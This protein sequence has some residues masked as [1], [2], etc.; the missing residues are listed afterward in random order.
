MP[1]SRSTRP[2]RLKSGRAQQL[3]L[4]APALLLVLLL[5]FLADQAPPPPPA[6]LPLENQTPV[7][8]APLI[9]EPRVPAN[10]TFT[11]TAASATTALAPP[12]AVDALFAAI[13]RP[14][15]FSNYPRGPQA[16]R[17]FQTP[18][19]SVVSE[20]ALNAPPVPLARTPADGR[21]FL[22]PE[23]IDLHTKSARRMVLDPASLEQV[24]SGRAG[25]LLVPTPQG[26]VLNVELRQ[27]K[28]RGGSTHTLQGEVAGEP[29]KSSAQFVYHDGVL[30]GSVARFHL[31]QEIEY[32]IL[33]DGHLMVRELDQ[34]SMRDLCNDPGAP[35]VAGDTADAPEQAP[36]QGGTS[37]PAATGEETIAGDTPGYTTVD[38]VVGY[39]KSAREADGGHAQIEARIVA[40]VDRMNLAFSNSQVASTELMLL[41]T[42]EDP[43]Y[44]FPGKTAGD[45]GG[46]DELG[47]LENTAASNPNLNTVSDYAT[48]LGADLQAFVL[49][50]AD[51]SAGVAYRPGRSS[52]TARDYMTATRITFA[53]ELGHNFGARHSWGDTSGTDA[54][55]NVHS[56]GWRLA[57]EGHPRV[58]TIMAYDWAWGSGVR[59]PY[60]AN[61]AV[62]YQGARTGQ[63]DGYNA[64]G[65]AL[66]D[67]RYVSG[68]YVGSLGAGFN[69]S[70]P[71]LGARNAPYLLTQAAGRAALRTRSAFQ[72]VTPAT[73]VTWETGSSREIYWRGGDHS[74]TVDIE[75]YR[76]G[77][78]QS[79]LVSGRQGH[80]R[81]Y[82]WAIPA[83][84]PS[85][86]NYM[87][88]IRRNG[89][90]TADSGLF[91]I[92]G[93]F[94]GVNPLTGLESTGEQGG[95]FAPSEAVY[96]LTNT[97][98]STLQWTAEASVPWVSLGSTGGS[99]SAGGSTPLTVS[100]NASANTLPSGLHT[101]TLTVSAG[102]IHITR[103]L[104][105]LV[106]GA[107]RLAVERPEGVALP[108]EEALDFGPWPLRF[109][110]R[111][112]FTLRNAGGSNLTLGAP[113]IAS[114]GGQFEFVGLS[115]TT[116]GIMGTAS[117]D[118]AFQPGSPGL[119][120]AVL[121][122]SSNDP[123]APLVS[124]PLVGR[125]VTLPGG[126]EMVH[127][128][129]FTAAGIQPAN[130]LPLG[131]QVVFSASTTAH[132]AEL[133]RSDGTAAGTYLV[134][135][136]NPG[137]S[138]SSISNLTRLG[139]RAFFSATSTTHGNELWVTDG[140]L[141]GTQLVRDILPGGSGAAPT[142]LHALG[143][144]LYFSASDGSS[145]AELWR[146]DGTTAGTTQVTDIN[147]GSPGS[148]PQNLVSIGSTLLFTAITTATGRELWRSNGTAGGTTLV[149]DINNH[150][151]DSSIA[152]LTVLGSTLFFTANDGSNGIELWKSDGTTAGTVLVKDINPGSASSSPA[153]LTALNG[154]LYFTATTAADGSELWRSDGTS[155]GTQMVLDIR[156]GN[157]SGVTTTLA[158][159][160]GQ[161]FFSANT[162]ANGSEL[163]VSNGTAAGTRML[164]DLFPGSSSASPIN[165]CQAGGALYFSA[166]NDKG[167]ELWKT[168]GT[169][170]GTVLVR[171]INPGTGSSS[172]AAL[173][174]LNDFLLFSAD[175]GASG[176]ELWRSDGTLAGTQPVGE[177]IAGLVSSAPTNLSAVGET[178]YFRG[179]NGVDGNE[180]WRT[181]GSY[182][183]TSMVQDISAG[184]AS[185]NPAN[186]TA[187]PAVPGS[188]VFT[189][190][191]S[192]AG[193][194]IHVS[195]GSPNGTTLLR[196]IDAAP[197]SSSPSDFLA[198]HE[199]IFFSAQDLYSGRELWK[200]N[201]T[202][203]GT[204]QVKDIDAGSGS[205]SPANLSR[206]H[207]ILLF[208]ASSGLLGTEL[209][210]SDGTS[211]GTFMVA[212]LAPG[213]ASSS[214]VP[215]TTAIVG[216]VMLFAATGA[217]GRE[218]WRTDGTAGGTSLVKDINPGAT[219]SNPG[220]AVS[221]GDRAVFSAGNS[222]H[223]TELWVSDGTGAGTHLLL[224]INPGSSS[225]SPL[226]LTLH[227]GHVYFTAV[228]AAHGREL[229]KTDGTTEGTV[230]VRDI[231]PGPASSNPGGLT[232]ANGRIFF[233]AVTSTQGTELWV[234][235]GTEAGTRLVADL[236][237][238]PVSSNPTNITLAGSRLYFTATHPLAF[239]QLFS[240][241][242]TGPAR[243]TVEQ[244]AGNPL[245]AGLSEIHAGTAVVGLSSTRVLTLVNAGWQALEISALSWS[246]LHAATFASAPPSL[247]PIPP[248]ESATVEITF[249]PDA[250]LP[251][252]AV[253]TIQSNDP[254]QPQF[255]VKIFGD[256]DPAPIL[257]VEHPPGTP[258]PAVGAQVFF[259]SAP[260]ISEAVSRAL[261]VRNEA[262]E[263]LLQITGHSL[264]GPHA[265]DFQIRGSFPVTLAAGDAGTFEVRFDP[266]G[267]G[268][269]TA[270]LTI[271]TND[272][273]RQSLTIA[274]IA[275]ATAVPGP[276]QQIVSRPLEAQ[277]PGDG[278]FRLPAF[279]TSGLPLS[280][281]VLAGPVHAGDNGWL[282]PTGGPG[283][284]TLLL[285]QPG[286]G[287]YNPAPPQIITFV[288]DDWPVFTRLFSGAGAAM[289]AALTANGEALWTWGY[290]SISGYL[291]DNSS[292]GRLSP[293]IIP[294]A[295]PW[296]DIAVGFNHGLGIKQNGTL[297][298]WGS[299]GNGQ[300][301]DGT[302]TTRTSPTQ[303]GLDKTWIS[304]AG[305]ASHSA[306]VA[307]DGSLWTWG[308][309]S[310]GQ[311]GLGDTAQRVSPAR[312]GVASHWRQVACGG[313]FTLALT[314][315]G[316]LWAF[317]ANSS[318]QLG[319]ATFTQSTAPV[320]VGADSDWSFVVCGSAFSLALKA[321]GTL[322]AWGSGAS[323]QLGRN[324]TL[325]SHMP[326]QVGTDDDWVQAA[327]G[328]NTATARKADGS[329][330][331]W[332]SNGDGQLA[333]GGFDNRL[334]PAL[335]ADGTDWAQ[336]CAGRYHT[337]VLKN[338]GRVYV[339]GEGAHF[340]GAHPRALTRATDPGPSW[341]CISGH[342][343][344][345]MAIQEDGSLWGWGWNQNGPLGTGGTESLQMISRIGL[346]TIWESLSAGSHN[347]F[348][349]HTLAV[350]NNGTL[351][352][353]GYNASSQ[354]GDGTLI[355]RTSFTQISAATNWREVA[356]G[357][358]HSLAVRS[359]GSLWAWGLNSNGQLGDGTTTTRTTPTRVGNAND[360]ARVTAGYNH[361]LALK[362]D[363]SLWAWGSN[364][365]GQLGQGHTTSPQ[366]SPLP[367]GTDSDWVD[368]AAGGHSLAVKANGSLWAWGLNGSG[369]LG[370][371]DFT[372]RSFPV[373]V[374]SANHWTRVFISR[375]SS[376]ALTADG[377]LFGAGENHTGQLGNGS[378]TT[379]SE[380]SLIA[381]GGFVEAAPGSRSLVARHADGSLWTAGTASIGTLDSG[382]SRT[383]FIQVLP[384]LQP[385]S[386]NV[387]PEDARS[388]QLTA[389]SGLPVQV[390]LLS[391]P[392]VV[393]G[394]QI[395]HAGQEGTTARFLAWQ[396]G[397]ETAWNAAAPV[398]IDLV[399]VHAMVQVW[400]GPQGSS[401]LASGAT[402]DFGGGYQPDP[403]WREFTVVNT[404]SKPLTLSGL[405]ASSG[406][407]LDTASLVSELDAGASTTFAARF[408]PAFEE[409]W[410][411]TITIS[412]NDPDTPSFVMQV[413]G[414]GQ[415]SPATATPRIVAPPDHSIVHSGSDLT[416]AVVAV[417]TESMQYQWKRNGKTIPGAN[418]PELVLPAISA[419][420]A[421]SYTVTVKAGQ[422]VASRAAHV[423]VVP[424]AAAAQ[425]AA[426]GKSI[427]LNSGV[428][429]SV[430]SC[431][432]TLDG[433]PVTSEPRKAPSPDGRTLR[434][435]NAQA[436][437][438]GRYQCV[439][440]APGGTLAAGEIDLAVVTAP[441]GLVSSL[442]LPAAF[443][444]AWYRHQIEVAPGAQI[445]PA[446]F[447]VRGLP[448]G[449]KVDAATG[450]ISGRPTRSGEFH[451]T[452]FAS[453][454]R[455]TSS[456]EAT[457]QI[458]PL[459]SG[460]AGAYAGLVAR[461][462]ALNHDHGGSLALSVAPS[463]ASS[464]KLTL[465]GATWRFKGAVIIDPQQTLAP[466]LLIQIQRPGRPPP[467][468][469]TLNLDF[470]PESSTLTG[471]ASEAEAE[472]PAD[473]EGWGRVWHAR[474]N[475][476]LARAG[477]HAFAL[478]LAAEDQFK[479]SLPQGNG[480][481]AFTVSTNGALRLAGRLAEGAP[482]L[483]GTFI[484][485]AGQIAVH[486]LPYGKK[487]P[488]SLHGRID[489]GL[490][491]DENNPA[492]NPLTGTL[493]W[494]RPARGSG[495]LYPSGF[496][497]LALTVMGGVFNPTPHLLGLANPPENV[498]LRFSEAG[499]AQS[500]TQLGEVSVLVDPGNRVI[501]APHTASVTLKAVPAKGHFNGRFTLIDFHWQKP[502]PA[503]WRR[504]VA[505][506]GLIVPYADGTFR[507]HGFFLLPQLPLA[508]PRQQPPL[509]LSGQVLFEK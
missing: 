249:T 352:A 493:T 438:I 46:A 376:I 432:W 283:A 158:V 419:T 409:R 405:V 52:I 370:L 254:V 108:P 8:S 156:A 206:L 213:I 342:G 231:E 125:G 400:D 287:A 453:N 110:E 297:W 440:N 93:E 487:D 85:A 23:E 461:D 373:R 415:T 63:V 399:R 139:E 201:G 377:R 89:T 336:V 202:L 404:G 193:T 80:L 109:K 79:T 307:S 337:A 315:D 4:L 494:T 385:Q 28:N 293:A 188:F 87:M 333:N 332:G 222:V 270:N 12:P 328:F 21:V 88:R 57:P 357:Q 348:N 235:D 39:D 95:P 290:A 368:I 398:Q 223:G 390:K 212:D 187:L 498:L 448:S 71:S 17:Q 148:A 305:G 116:I 466:K 45:M 316:Q 425:I 292:P 355:S 106:T 500:L 191:T 180:L 296:R 347:I 185:S 54:A 195:N 14:S 252:E 43:V 130:L 374:G 162:G 215:S 308:L 329:V 219:S 309:N 327:A 61:P 244:P 313:S 452:L 242:T 383:G 145:G 314:V 29:Q 413:T 311:L 170:A 475:P 467:A 429:G 403:P 157:L 205:S 444:G 433:A 208:S 120:E 431:V 442:Q 33:A 114:G 181:D 107:P 281:E 412:S 394:N 134:R 172:P 272:P 338:D 416:M 402:V 365:S 481:A 299:N 324:S 153:N 164:R 397:D 227:D 434:I 496:G 140:T 443:V 56:Y 388:W 64:T 477:Y 472:V 13:G 176:R 115:A 289:T 334:T 38:V 462:N 118:V 340:S 286:G 353:A 246:G 240:I 356:A 354:L 81:R 247:N 6:A 253:L 366:S 323:G 303:T 421:G 210:R 371:G 100:F 183:G 248:G 468:P 459:A 264:T 48:A 142:N 77:I 98:G 233:R 456:A 184:S 229:W 277:R 83:G 395:R 463:A 36:D 224:D 174:A 301:G 122:I 117:L 218:L 102:S 407:E 186:I 279:A 250:A 27:I 471:L 238:G 278:P 214:P 67:P 5:C 189:A 234:C 486:A 261:S 364:G 167:H 24:I 154:V 30:H 386:I 10:P 74:D 168:D 103:P 325:N 135:D 217:E 465:G 396:P 68:G 362:T 111:R 257:I 90:L 298:T 359:D 447:R 269:R 126:M 42:V 239:N 165:W 330:W 422:S 369:Q 182:E 112:R 230:L 258:L 49:R 53:H 350:K 464:G 331:G 41:G 441:P 490:G 22:L 50:Q 62:T 35:P 99:L 495:T 32:R 411:G 275:E 280:I 480:F 339:A 491:T 363:G 72:V 358:S 228:T 344:H 255:Q 379:H 492:D 161:L 19:S 476:A 410:T 457:I 34:R 393:E 435:K 322:W 226:N 20:A 147:S 163:W 171:D 59:I 268:T 31:E 437:D 482:V 451:L 150:S 427:T 136:I 335:L 391:G 263:T 220:I 159:H 237:P 216:S 197:T 1:T 430:L 426:A 274:L 198:V 478:E 424:P 146:S 178:L 94:L 271:F 384:A 44:V 175:D 319:N 160:D 199:S 192:A 320:R 288:M 345:F 392:G 276:N 291:G 302:T 326:I 449:L 259:G 55:T 251:R 406:W 372:S 200:T 380:F 190:T 423:T 428:M 460:L 11:A 304:A 137:A 312:V 401:E 505:Y 236:F 408:V 16:Q 151:S 361:S 417:C 343:T 96:T 488:G 203:A 484:G 149:K 177:G 473:V 73:A 295:V 256:G 245:L 483:Q 138:G 2:F 75:L 169:E 455:G 381:S 127:P 445:Q 367:V 25:R 262:P 317:G 507:G 65:D 318:G 266:L 26:T 436:T 497:P 97:S 387:P 82:Q 66:S 446:T 123:D 18:V 454:G 221:L 207:G 15:N 282:T 378:V 504:R 382:R 144:I 51:G 232:P 420:N 128:I 351:W 418:G 294:S 499:L 470:H 360:W 241:D 450:L 501:P 58:R 284:V 3:A 124:I 508:D 506:Q 260:V 204:L 346:E 414:I 243:L 131:N 300:I 152:N 37:S 133:W 321:N 47:D 273:L 9:A 166:F 113:V 469:I 306:A 105:L 155:A 132:G 458:A 285:S 509:V 60:F 502:A 194:E 40:S 310:N 84:L 101:G 211:D 69:G 265:A 92:T 225:S 196:D 349:N 375:N 7:A 70:N 91:T 489:Q 341:Q 479:P 76:G 78:L 86:S 474:Q 179:S 104:S 389:T 267:S 503:A 121:Q 119:H 129:N 439:I 141:S 209:W 143:G 173:A 485:P